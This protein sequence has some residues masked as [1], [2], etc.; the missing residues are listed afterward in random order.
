MP[1]HVHKYKRFKFG[2]GRVAFRCMA[3]GCAHYVLEELILGRQSI[4]WRCG[5]IFMID[6]RSARLA[7]PHCDCK[8]FQQKD[9]ALDILVNNILN[10]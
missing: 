1:E 3:G 2:N 10:G 8:K 9:P 6:E 5:N 7:K 4:C